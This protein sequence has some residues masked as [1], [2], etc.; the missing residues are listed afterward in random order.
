MSDNPSDWW[1]EDMPP[2]RGRIVTTDEMNEVWRE[3]MKAERFDVGHSELMRADEWNFR[4]KG[5]WAYID[6]FGNVHFSLDQYVWW[7]R[8]IIWLRRLFK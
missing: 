8:P 4:Q 3:A 5:T 2:G 1:C 7:Y 6:E